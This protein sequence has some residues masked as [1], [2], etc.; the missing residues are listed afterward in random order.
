MQ[1]L[2]SLLAEA[3]LLMLLRSLASRLVTNQY[4]V[5]VRVMFVTVVAS[6][7]VMESIVFCFSRACAIVAGFSS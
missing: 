2:R 5:V 4:I 1:S 6:V 7:V 3:L